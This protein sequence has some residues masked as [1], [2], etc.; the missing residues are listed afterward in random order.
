MPLRNCWLMLANPSALE[1]GSMILATAAVGRTLRRSTTLRKAKSGAQSRH[2]LVLRFALWKWEFFRVLNVT[3][4]LAGDI[5][6]RLWRYWGKGGWSE[7]IRN[8][9]H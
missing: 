6:D 5:R 4:T 1:H 8:S 2:D 7:R 9:R 3:S